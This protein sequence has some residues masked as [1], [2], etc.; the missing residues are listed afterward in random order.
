MNAHV[1]AALVDLASPDDFQF[2]FDGTMLHGRMINGEPWLVAHDVAL[3]LSHRKTGDLTRTLD[4]DEKGAH[5]VR[6]LGG[7]QS[8]SFVSAPGLW[9]AICQ[10]RGVK[11]LPG[12]TRDRV[13]RFQRRV[14][15]EILPAIQQ[16]GSYSA[17]P[18]P[19]P[20]PV[21][22]DVRDPGQLAVIASQLVALTADL[23]AKVGQS[24]ARF[25]REQQAHAETH[26][27]LEDTSKLLRIE[28]H[29]RQVTSTALS[30]AHGKI[31]ALRPAVLAQ[32]RIAASDEDLSISEAAVILFVPRTAV[33]K[34]LLDIGY[35][36]HI[37]SGGKKR[38]RCLV[39]GV[40]SGWVRQGPYDVALAPGQIVTRFH[41]V[42]TPLGMAGLAEHFCRGVRATRQPVIPGV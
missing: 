17:R 18:L 6:T 25:D 3:S 11:S 39:P 16:T 28:S 2:D 19:V 10:R 21:Q 5:I 37:V 20:A 36:I 15:H 30:E 38:L 29:A 42:V 22:I 8:V 35:V 12:A 32:A 27:H 14:F 33:I 40:D 26:A 1:P 4:D 9:K 31:D 34:H 24:E 7:P 23:Q 41:P 13:E